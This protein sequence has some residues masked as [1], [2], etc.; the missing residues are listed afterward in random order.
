MAAEPSGVTIREATEEDLP[1]LIELLAQLSLA[2]P[3]E[4]H[5]PPLPARYYETFREIRADRRQRL[6]VLETDE[7]IQATLALV[8][9]PNLSHVGKPFAIVE[10]V[11]VDEH[12]RGSGYGEMLMRRS[13]DEARAAGCYRLSLFS[14][15]QRADAHRFYQRLGFHAS[16]EGFRIEL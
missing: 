15:K 2:E 4:E 12:A 6:F 14:N 9:V 7:T 3:R 1:R 5:G 11:V 13:I 8:I 10:N 16:H